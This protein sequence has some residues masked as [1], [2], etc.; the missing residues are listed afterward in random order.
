VTCSA[1]VLCPPPPQT[2]SSGTSPKQTSEQVGALQRFRSKT[3]DSAPKS[4]NP[5]LRFLWPS[6]L[7]SPPK[8][9]KPGA[10]WPIEHCARTHTETACPQAS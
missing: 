6:H 4:K 7:R 1:P 9:K 2:A 3:P 10:R 5:L 8:S